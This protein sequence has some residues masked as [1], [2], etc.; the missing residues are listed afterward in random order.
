MEPGMY[1]CMS[2]SLY[3]WLHTAS[4]MSWTGNTPLH[5]VKWHHPISVAYLDILLYLGTGWARHSAK[6]HTYTCPSSYGHQYSV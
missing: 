5:R 3:V 1:V 2:R 6:Q 4:S